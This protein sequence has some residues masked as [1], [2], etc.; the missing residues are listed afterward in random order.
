MV[1][2]L[3]VFAVLLSACSSTPMKFYMLTAEVGDAPDLSNS[4]VNKN[5]VLGLGPI[6]LP[7]YLN[8][9][10]IVVAITNNQFSIDEH[11]RW[12]ERLD[13]NIYRSLA[14]LLANRLGVEQ[15]I[16]YPWAQRQPID[17]Q[18]TLDFFEFHQAADGNSRL[19]AQW[20]IKHQEQTALGKRFECSLA[21]KQDA[22]DI[23]KAQSVCL[24]QLGLEIESGLR[25]L[26]G[27]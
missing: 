17:Y 9:P 4:A 14:L 7:D 15:V 11:R 12:A 3:L 6:H 16:R 10:Q 24:G 27:K 22:E 20:Q 23:V 18:V 1:Y 19:L 2:L 25:Q 13:E 21:S 26:I 5:L 8:R